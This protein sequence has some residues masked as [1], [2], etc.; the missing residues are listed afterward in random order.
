[1]RNSRSKGA[2]KLQ[3]VIDTHSVAQAISAAIRRTFGDFSAPTKRYARVAGVDP[4]TAR[5][6]WEGLNCPR[7][8][9][10][11]RLMAESDAALEAV[12]AMSGRLTPETVERL[13]ELVTAPGGDA[14]HEGDPD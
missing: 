11:I 4:R 6:H 12:L 7:A 2:R 5:N 3:A 9:E 13:L 14:G 8:P 1:M 10:L